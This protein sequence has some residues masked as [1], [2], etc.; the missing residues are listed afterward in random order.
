MDDDGPKKIGM[1]K[2]FGYGFFGGLGLWL[3]G[4]VVLGTFFFCAM[5]GMVSWYDG[6]Q[7]R[8][9][10]ERVADEKVAEEK[11]A[12]R[13]AERV[14]DQ[15]RHRDELLKAW[16]VGRPTDGKDRPPR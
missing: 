12:E 4:V 1:A 3:A 5:G 2:A 6:V 15:Q 8:R 9:D 11:S 16:S 13:S 10:A 7:Q 14:A